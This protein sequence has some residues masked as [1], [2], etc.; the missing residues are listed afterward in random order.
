MYPANCELRTADRGQADVGRRL[1]ILGP[2]GA[3]KGTQAEKL[4]RAIGIPHVST[5]EMLRDHVERRT[6]LGSRAKAIMDAGDLVHDEIVI[7]M[8]Q[9]RLSAPDAACG[10]LLDGFPRTL[11]QAVSLDEA[12]GDRTLDAAIVIEVPESEIVARMRARGRSDDTEDAVQTRL[13]LYREQTEPLVDFYDRR[14]S[15]IRVD[16]V[17]SVLEV[18]TRIVEALA[19]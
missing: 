5:G 16:G 10:F 11:S 1:L 9:Q 19:R 15:M 18:L 6:D 2:P 3:G 4:C 7:A 14:G 8:V 17:G 13:A 12:L